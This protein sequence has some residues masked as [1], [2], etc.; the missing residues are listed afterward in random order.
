MTEFAALPLPE[1]LRTLSPD[2]DARGL[3]YAQFTIQHGGI[4]LETSNPYTY[5]TYPWGELML[6]SREQQKQRRATSAPA[7]CLDLGALT[8][9]TPL[10]R[11]IGMVLE[12]QRIRYCTIEAEIA[13]ASDPTA[14]RVQVRVGGQMRSFAEEV[15]QQLL[16][17]RARYA[18]RHEGGS[19][20]G[21][22]RGWLPWR[23]G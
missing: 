17:N 11:L 2:L 1:A 3:S 6:R 14:C 10:L 13:P 19:S 21:P 18:S 20:G 7:P 16:R 8:R 5:R 15:Q 12:E 4:T 22:R 23:R 9:W